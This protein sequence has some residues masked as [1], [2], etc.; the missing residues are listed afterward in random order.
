MSP[1]TMAQDVLKA[2]RG[3][4]ERAMAPLL[5]RIKALEARPDPAPMLE[6]VR[7]LV[8][9]PAPAPGRD[10]RDALDLQIG[11]GLDAT[12][13]YPAGAFVAAAGGLLRAARPTDPVDADG[14]LRAAGW[15]PIVNGLRS[16][17]TAIE[18]GGRVL[19]TR[20]RSTIG[21]EEIRHTTAIPVERGVH[22]DAKDYATG[23]VVEWAGEAW[24][25]TKDAP[26]G[27]PDSGD[28]WRRLVRRG[29]EGKSVLAAPA[30]TVARIVP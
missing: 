20:I 1:E 29:R 7:A 2:V 30:P 14:D 21:A 8:D 18:D 17:E 6:L 23:D 15:V 11:D 13:S 22:R 26:T 19:V 4:V 25:A 9:R 12:R 3:F 24:I 16:I 5:D 10:G 27:K 28:G